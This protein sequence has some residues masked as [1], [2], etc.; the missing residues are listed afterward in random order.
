MCTG[1]S[2]RDQAI[3]HAF[4]LSDQQGMAPSTIATKVRF[5]QRFVEEL[6]E[7]AHDRGGGG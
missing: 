4:A 6:L 7:A 1:G 2:Q 5:P 3:T